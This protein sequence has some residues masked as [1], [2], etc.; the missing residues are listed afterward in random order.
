MALRD[1]S[2]WWILHQL[3]RVGFLAD[4]CGFNESSPNATRVSRCLRGMAQSG[5][6]RA[7]LCRLGVAVCSPSTGWGCLRA[8]YRGKKKGSRSLTACRLTSGQ[9]RNSC[10]LVACRELMH[11]ACLLPDL[12][13][14]AASASHPGCGK[15]TPGAGVPPLPWVCPAGGS[16]HGGGRPAALCAR[17]LCRQPGESAFGCSACCSRSKLCCSPRVRGAPVAHRW[18]RQGC[19]GGG[20]GR[21]RRGGFPRAPRGRRG[22]GLRCRSPE[23]R[24]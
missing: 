23:R 4:G 17:G 20:R 24:A 11:S 21:R 5:Y 6:Q 14:N 16:A 12:G 8:F 9:G 13:T 2:C 3:P 19:A 10:L 1:P 22:S 7:S 18:L 15:V